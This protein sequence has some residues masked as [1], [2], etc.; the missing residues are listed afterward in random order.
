MEIM[1]LNI[2]SII[3]T[4]LFGKLQILHK[5]NTMPRTFG[6][7]RTAEIKRIQ[8]KVFLSHPQKKNWRKPCF[9]EN[10]SKK[11]TKKKKVMWKAWKPLNHRK[12]RSKRTQKAPEPLGP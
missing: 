5:G 8:Q 7:R 6:R 2:P 1:H 4:T 11:K 10:R 12:I 9:I 3:L